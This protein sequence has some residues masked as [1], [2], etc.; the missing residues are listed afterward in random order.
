MPIGAFVGT[1]VQDIRFASRLLRRQ[2][3]ATLITVLTLAIAIGANSAIF[4]IMDGLLLRGLPVQDP[5]GL[6]LVKWSAHK[7]PSYHSSSSYGDCVS[8][9]RGDNPSGCS[10]SLPL[11]E[12]IRD[13]AASF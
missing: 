12:D 4:S 6:M 13:H 3:G 7:P 8:Q 11:Y 1:T 5:E 10:F 9:Y 2:F